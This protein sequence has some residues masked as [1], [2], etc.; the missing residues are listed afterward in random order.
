MYGII[1]QSIQQLVTKELG[2]ETWLKIINKSGIDIYE[3]KNHEQ[4]DDKYTYLLASALAEHLQSPVSTVLKRLGEFWI[5]DISLKKYPGMMASGGVNFREFM[6]N[7]PKFHNRVYLSYPELVAP[8]FKIRD[9]G[10]K[11]AVE[12]HSQRE[13]LTALMEGMLHGIVKMFDEKDISI[14]LVYSKQANLADHD[15]FL[16]T[17]RKN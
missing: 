5:M 8:E 1:N 15:L 11:L 9:E 17:W 14:D 7:L 4:Y 12:Y 2:E 10:D 13:G 6:L 16:I 3:F